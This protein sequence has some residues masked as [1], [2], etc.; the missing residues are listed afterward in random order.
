MSYQKHNFT[1]GAVLLASQLND[2]DNQIEALSN[3]E[4]S[5]SDD[6]KTALLNCF[7]NVAW[8]NENGQTYYDALYDSLYS[9][10]M[11]FIT[12]ILTGCATSNNATNILKNNSYVTT[13]T[14]NEGYTLD[15]A[16]VSIT[17]GGNDVT[18]LYY[19]SGSINIP[20]VTGDLVI[21]V[22]ATS[23]VTSIT[24]V[25]TQGSVTI[26]DTDSL[27]TLRQYL[28]VTAT[29]SDSTTATVT[30]YTLSGTLDSA[31]SVITVSYGGKT[32]NI[33][34]AVNV[35][36]LPSGYT[37]YDYITVS[38][39]EATSPTASFITLNNQTDMNA[40]SLE[41]KLRKITNGAEPT[42]NSA[43]FG[44]RNESSATSSYSGYLSSAINIQGNIRGSWFANTLTLSVG[45]THTLKYINGLSSPY[46]V[47]V[48]DV[49]V[50]RAWGETTYVIPYGLVLFTNPV[51][52]ANT[53][54]NL[55][56]WIN[57]GEIRL[58]NSDGTCVGRYIPVVNSG[59]V[60]GMYDI[61]SEA[62]YSCSTQTYATVGNSNC[63]YAVGNW[64]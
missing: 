29:Y 47:Q 24:A 63:K 62:F 49:I 26:Y 22:T 2:M 53:A 30:D 31:T 18:N 3:Q 21:T 59:N 40:L 61:V 44:I 8:I 39:I 17:M 28:V 58:T 33:N 48:D 13:I 9:D 57:I 1:P 42:G 12:N 20:N 37:K 60:I 23:A 56:R 14:A 55:C 45:T 43:F 36:T 50:E 54:M 19:S 15:G 4:S 34:V 38:K 32:T 7:E 5:F 6:F 41:M 16:T 11:W 10:N 52:G 46:K 64:S 25:F 27:D 35:A 51:H